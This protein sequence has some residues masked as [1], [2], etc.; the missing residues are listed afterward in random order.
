VLPAYDVA[1]QMTKELAIILR[2]KYVYSELSIVNPNWLTMCGYRYVVG[3]N[4]FSYKK[5]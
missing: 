2:E 1:A 3:V 4:N 5:K